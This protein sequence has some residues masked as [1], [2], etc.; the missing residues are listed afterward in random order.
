MSLSAVEFGMDRRDIL[1]LGMGAAIYASTLPANGQTSPTARTA[2][3][4]QLRADITINGKT[5]TYTMDGG[6]NLGN[7]IG[8]GFVQQNVR[9]VHPS[10]EFNP[11]MEVYF[12]PDVAPSTRIEVIVEMWKSGDLAGSLVNHPKTTVLPAGVTAANFMAPLTIAV[13][14]ESGN[15]VADHLGRTVITAPYWGWGERY[16]FQTAPRPIIR[17]PNQL[18]AANLIP[19]FGTRNLPGTIKPRDF[20]IFTYIN[21]MDLAGTKPGGGTG[22]RD[23]IGLTTEQGANYLI[24]PTDPAAIQAMLAWGE[25]SASYPI[26]LRDDATGAPISKLTYPQCNNYNLNDNY[27]GDPCIVTEGNFVAPGGGDP[28]HSAP[29]TSHLASLSY[30]PAISTGDP[31]HLEEQQFTANYALIGNSQTMNGNAVVGVSGG[32]RAI[33]WEIRSVFEAWA[34]TKQAELNG[35]LP[36][37]LLPSSDF[38]T[39]LRNCVPFFEQW[40]KSTARWA[41]VFH[42]LPLINDVEPWENKYQAVTMM[43]GVLLGRSDYKAIAEWVVQDQVNWVSGRTGAPPAFP[44]PYVYVTATPASGL[45]GNVYLPPAGTPDDDFYPDLGTAFIAWATDQI[46]RNVGAGNNGSINQAEFNALLAD[47]L[48]GGNLIETQGDYA[49]NYPRGV[50]AFA[51]YLDALGLISM[52]DAPACLDRMTKYVANLGGVGTRSA[53]WAFMPSLNGSLPAFAPLPPPVPLPRVVRS[54]TPH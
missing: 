42:W 33:A 36:S 12:R 50:L 37:W 31:F 29:D 9:G 51:T 23:D 19:P 8:P 2:T 17:T 27:Q 28:T 21:P 46:A 15:P 30:I 3:A 48:N 38:D 34:A 26:H 20:S 16:R 39:I 25:A 18:V 32:A 1:G 5:F 54:Q 41:T 10:P 35:P 43:L 40:T 7:F 45:T 13:F 52:P 22:E 44:D 6:K 4:K 47:P 11:A 49:G 53:R 24:N 14:D